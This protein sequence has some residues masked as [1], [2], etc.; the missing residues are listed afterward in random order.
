MELNLDKYLNIH[1]PGYV[2][3]ILKDNKYEEHVIGNKCT[4]PTI[5]PTTSNTLYDIASLTKTFTAVLVYIAYEEGKLNLDDT[6]YNLD[7]RF[8]NLKEVT[9]KNL[10]SHNQDT[11]TNGYLGDAKTKEEFY[12][13]L[14]TSYVKN[15]IYTYVDVHYIILSTILEKLYNKS[16]KELVT[17]KIINKLNLIHT[18]FDP[19]PN[20]TASNNYENETI[21]Y[22]TPGIIHDK[23][24][25]RAKELGIT[26]GHASIFTTC[27]DLITF[28]ES[29][30]NYSLLKKET[31]ELMLS[32][33]DIY[34]YVFNFLKP[35]STSSDINE[36]YKDYKKTDN[37]TLVPRTY[38]N[39]GARYK[40]KI[41]EQNDV[42][43]ICSD[44]SISFSGFTGPMYTIDFDNRIIVVVMCNVMHRTTLTRD[45]RRLGSFKIMNNIYNNLLN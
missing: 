17:E 24:A 3:G 31:I 32:H 19:D 6:V 4:K 13:I 42:P 5:E 27:K 8:I 36:M 38:N 45:E 37:H 35:Y 18:T 10:L 39:M 33:E 2:I 23:K 1:S 44:N 29:F 15:K 11:W 14:F 9:I 30:F 40:N 7:N 34:Q 22:V 16:Y 43:Y 25:R 28:L 12:N 20:N 26:T 21:D 41:I